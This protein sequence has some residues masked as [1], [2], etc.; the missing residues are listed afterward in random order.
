[1][2]RQQR[3]HGATLANT[4]I[5]PVP[6]TTV[7]TYTGSTVSLPV[8]R[9]KQNI[10]AG[11]VPCP[12]RHQGWVTVREGSFITAWK[13][14][15]LILSREWLDFCKTEGGKSVYTLFLTDV[16]GI[17][18]VE[19]GTPILEIKR[20]AD[21]TSSS[22]GDKEGGMR[23]LHVKT[24]TE[25]E[26]YGWI[27]FI[28][29]ACPG[30]GGVSNPT[31]FSHAVHVGFNATS[32]EFVGLPHE[33]AQLLSASTIT[34]EDYA[35]NPQ[36]VIEAVDF[37][38]DL[39]KKS[40]NP[41]QYLA[42]SPTRATRLLEELNEASGKDP[43]IPTQTNESPRPLENAYTAYG[44]HVK[45]T[46][47]QHE[48]RRERSQERRPN[49]PF[50]NI[51][52]SP[53]GAPG[54]ATPKATQDT[55]PLRPAPLAPKLRRVPAQPVRPIPQQ[56]AADTA[57]ANPAPVP[58]E[59][60]PKHD[61]QPAQDPGLTPIPV[62]SMRRQT[63]RHQT[64]SEAE[65]ISKLQT[66]VSSGNPDDSYARQKK[67]GQGASGSVYVAKI[68]ATAVGTARDIILDR[69]LNTRV[70]IKEMVLARQ[71]RKE[72]LVDEIMI[73]KENRHENIINFLEAFLVNENRQLW[74]VIDY[75]DGGALNDIIDNNS[76]ISER[77][78]A[79]ICRETCKGLQHLHARCV[80][81]R[82]IKSDNVLMDS[83]GNIKITDFGFCAKLNERRSKRAT[84]VGTT[85]WMAPEVVRQ[86]K[87]SYK[88]DVWSLGIMAIEMAEMEP[89]YMDEQPLRALYLIATSGTPPLRNPDKHSPL[90]KSFLAR[91]LRVDAEQRASA[92]AL[93]E[94]EFLKS[95]G[96]VSELVE[97]LAYKSET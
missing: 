32:K 41:E 9:R 91:C 84:M 36:A 95:G 12:I 58:P 54:K 25:D 20:K 77:H 55:Q 62:P 7:T 42:L 67:I 66:V 2:S 75:M 44:G 56:P 78:M 69:G 4:A 82:D 29:T 28:Y 96:S 74:V 61:L 57:T 5:S 40:N 8:A 49:I 24:K 72:L 10:T 97:L 92:D 63:I 76:T 93:L 48:Q 47:Q 87:Y 79:T 80:I 43:T 23:I 31:N 81:H 15:Y 22:P 16:V 14:R 68:K 13:D 94:H 27:D 34:K 46:F 18:R 50:K 59:V 6:G 60:C 35:R 37:Y 88:I 71:A 85:Y 86:K 19:T 89:P 64:T 53:P 70:A 73:M 3:A 65:L 1:M 26:L 38:S 17:G 33:W 39:T 30:L 52:V 51:A 90:L 21:G 83:R 45:L 11:L